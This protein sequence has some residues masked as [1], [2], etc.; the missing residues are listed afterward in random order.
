MDSFGG[1]FEL[2]SDDISLILEH[3]QQGGG[4]QQATL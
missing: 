1:L 3:D 2:R 4:M